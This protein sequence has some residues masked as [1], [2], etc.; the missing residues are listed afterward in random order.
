MRPQPPIP[1]TIIMT[2]PI[3]I[4]FCITELDSGGAERALVELVTRLDR[5]CFEPA[6]FCLGPRGV[7]ADDLERAGVPVTCFGAK[8]AWEVGVVFRLAK[9]LRAYRPAILQTWLFHANLLGRLAGRLAPVPIVVSG[10]R[11]AERRSR[12]RLW[13]DRLTQSL[14]DAHICVSRDVAD[15]SIRRGGLNASR[16]HVIANGVD[17]ERFAKAAPADLAPLGIP[18]GAKIILFAGRLDPQKDPLWLLNSFSAIH[19]R[20]EDV[21]LLF[22]GQGPLEPVIK[23]T[24][25]QLG[26]ENRVHLLGWRA[27][28]PELLKSAD[29]LVLPSKWE[30]MPNIVLEAFAAGLPVVA[31]EVEGIRDLVRDNETG[32]VVKSRDPDALIEPISRILEDPH[33]AVS[34]GQSAQALVFKKFTWEENTRSYAEIYQQLLSNA[35][36]A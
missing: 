36:S 8:R 11:V 27:D 16:V 1:L 28:V 29:V 14:V 6:V 35:N 32:W 26:L 24:I 30:G 31:A 10:I 34:L 7:L 25:G 9:A 5:Q 13:A 33:F 19:R 21:H 2:V 20:I 3:R 15:F 4:A 12:W 17:G 23:K 22:A 18:K